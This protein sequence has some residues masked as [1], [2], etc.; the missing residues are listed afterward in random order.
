MSYR[1][2]ISSVLLLLSW[3]AVR[4][5]DIPCDL[6]HPRHSTDL[7]R[8]CVA[9]HACNDSACQLNLGSGEGAARGAT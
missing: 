5:S 6:L 8:K 7:Y 4:K 9:C 1:V 2:V 3:G